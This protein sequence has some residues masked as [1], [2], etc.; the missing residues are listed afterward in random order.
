MYELRILRRATRDI[1]NLPKDYTKLVSQHIEQLAENP[2]PPGVKK[3][4]DRD[5][6]RLRVGPYRILYV[7]DDKVRVVTIYRVKHRREAYR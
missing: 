4:R 3:L 2:R 6:Y 7:I 5:D 1:A